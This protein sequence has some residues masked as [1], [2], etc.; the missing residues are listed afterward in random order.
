MKVSEIHSYDTHTNKCIPDL[1][2]GG[3]P[4]QFSPCPA[5]NA[6]TE[7]GSILK[8][9]LAK[10]SFRVVSFAG[11]P[12]P[13]TFLTVHPPQGGELTVWQDCGYSFVPFSAG[14]DRRAR[15]SITT[16]YSYV[17]ENI[18]GDT[19]QGTFALNRM[20]AIPSRM[21]DFQ[22]WSLSDLL[23][24]LG[25]SDMSADSPWPGPSPVPSLNAEGANKAKSILQW[26]DDYDYS[27][28]RPKN[29][30]QALDPGSFLSCGKAPG[31]CQ[32]NDEEDAS[33]RV[34]GCHTQ[35][36]EDQL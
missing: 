33:D 3:V 29:Q 31:R 14:P 35:A 15:E 1:A 27:A 9:G 17:I 23:E 21:H 25:L 28:S 34:P 30:P 36:P 19:A 11:L 7:T 12:V 8:H 6:L 26:L 10:D 22:S 20:D 4:V 24:I 16:Y 32:N 5:A 18:H 13:K 2:D